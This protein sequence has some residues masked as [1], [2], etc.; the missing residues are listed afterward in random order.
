MVSSLCICKASSSTKF[1]S[2]LKVDNT[3]FESGFVRFQG[4]LQSHSDLQ[5]IMILPHSASQP[6]F[7]WPHSLS[8]GYP[9][10]YSINDDNISVNSARATTDPQEGK[11]Q[12]EGVDTGFLQLTKDHVNSLK[13]VCSLSNWGTARVS[14]NY[15]EIGSS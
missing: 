7:I 12:A 6:Q 1:R 13:A 14:Y 3:V 5:C 10:H 9:W 11:S 8:H 15:T 4:E 2:L